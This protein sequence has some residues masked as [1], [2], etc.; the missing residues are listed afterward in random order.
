MA[1]WN[2][3]QKKKLLLL[4]MVIVI[5]KKSL[6]DWLAAGSTPMADIDPWADMASR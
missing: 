2:V 1:R 3:Q 4:E 5:E 6:S